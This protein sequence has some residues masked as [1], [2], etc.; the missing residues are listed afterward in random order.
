MLNVALTGNA[1]AGKSTVARWFADWGATIIDSDVLV[2]EAQ[3]P[4]SETLAAI[5]SRFGMSVILPDGSLDRAA[6]RQMVLGDGAA[7]TALNAIV[8]PAVHTRREEL[9]AKARRRG[10]RILV[11]DIPLLFEV[12]DPDSFDLVVLVESPNSIRHKRLVNRGLSEDEASQLMASQLPP[13]Q[14][15]ARADIIIENRG[16]L[17]ELKDAAREAWEKICSASGT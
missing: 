11:S 12:L 13:E 8:H 14:K 16:S 17:D 5:I 15:R 3:Q 10:D 2:A 6:L 4:G 1:A 7:R 9:V